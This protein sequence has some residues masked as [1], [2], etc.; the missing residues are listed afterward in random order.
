MIVLK[1]GHSVPP[2]TS[3]MHDLNVFGDRTIA[4]EA[5]K[6][7]NVSTRMAADRPPLQPTKHQVSMKPGPDAI[8]SNVKNEDVIRRVP[9]P[10]LPAQDEILQAGPGWRSTYVPPHQSSHPV[11]QPSS[12]YLMTP[13]AP[14]TMGWKAPMVWKAPMAPHASKVSEFPNSRPS[15][16]NSPTT[17]AP[18]PP[19]TSDASNPPNWA[20]SNGFL[21][22]SD[23]WRETFKH[24]NPHHN[25]SKPQPNPI[26]PQCTYLCITICRPNPEYTAEELDA[27]Q[28]RGAREV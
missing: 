28:P 1:H 2:Y 17:E 15:L 24:R 6:S 14:Q 5:I 3:T 26:E 13:E 7:E 25:D 20:T 4:F 19:S 9:A 22:Y 18:N 12:S 10:G 23:E 16:P 21:C 27:I 8:S 11:P